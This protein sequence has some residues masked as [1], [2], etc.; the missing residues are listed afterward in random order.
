MQWFN[1]FAIGLVS[2]LVLLAIIGLLLPSRLHVESSIDIAAPPANVFTVLNSAHVFNKWSP[3]TAPDP[4]AQY[5]YSGPWSGVGTHMDWQSSNPE[6]GSGSEIV[7]A[8]KPYQHLAVTFELAKR[9]TSDTALDLSP[10]GDGTHVVWSLDADFGW[11]LLE[12][13]TGLLLKQKIHEG[14]GTGLANLKH[15]VE[16]LPKT[17]LAGADIKLLQMQPLSIVY[18]SGKTTTDGRDVANALDAAYAKVKT[19]I[20]AHHLK[21]TGARMAVTRVWDPAHNNYEFDAA[22]PAAWDTLTVPV[23]SP[24]KLGQTLGGEVVLATYTGPYSGTGEVYN[25]ITVWLAANGLT[26]TGLTW[27]QYLN[28]PANTPDDKLVTRIYTPVR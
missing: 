26:A 18:A 10:D 21:V 13:Y 14:F 2:L 12:R 5:T 9:G 20:A 19:F 25:Q 6:L 24:V 22:I 8:S 15:F 4:D 3:W 7:T 23:N 1:R 16:C 11:N 28:D 17:D 27:E